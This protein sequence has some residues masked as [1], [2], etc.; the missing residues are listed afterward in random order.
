MLLTR[1][2]FANGEARRYAQMKKLIIPALLAIICV[3]LVCVAAGAVAII[4]W[5]RGQG[6]LLVVD[7]TQPI[8]KAIKAPIMPSEMGPYS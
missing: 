2:G 5:S 4:E 7:V 1:G 3:I 8:H 6:R